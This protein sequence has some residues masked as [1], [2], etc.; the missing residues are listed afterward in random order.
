MV[1]A[2]TFDFWDTLAADDSDEPKR[3]ERGLPTKAEARAHLFA[4]SITANVSAGGL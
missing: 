2:V 1:M 4:E 3:A